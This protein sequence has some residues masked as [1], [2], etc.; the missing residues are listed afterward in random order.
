MALQEKRDGALFYCPEM[1]LLAWSQTAK[2]QKWSQSPGLVT[3]V[4]IRTPDGYQPLLVL[5]EGSS[6]ESLLLEGMGLSETENEEKSL[7]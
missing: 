6:H 4:G 1:K 3:A 7:G 5:P 2:G